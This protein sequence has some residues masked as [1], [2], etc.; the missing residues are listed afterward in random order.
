VHP[1]NRT[2]TLREAARLQGFS[3]TFVFDG[4]HLSKQYEQ[5]G[6]AVPPPLA[7]AIGAK[8]SV[9]VEGAPVPLP[10]GQL[11]TTSSVAG[12][13]KPTVIEKHTILTRALVAA[14]HV[15]PGRSTRTH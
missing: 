2:I 14:R 13:M 11:R 3:D 10:V 6:N 1:Q 7:T 5:V 9:H 12:R 8:A 15:R 4:V